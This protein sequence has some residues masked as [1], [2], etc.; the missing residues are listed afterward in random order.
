MPQRRKPGTVER[1]AAR[2][3]A[4]AAVRGRARDRTL[5]RSDPFHDG[6]LALWHQR[7]VVL[8][9]PRFSSATDPDVLFGFVY[10]GARTLSLAE[11]FH[12][13][14]RGGELRE[15]CPVCGGDLLV[16]NAGTGLTFTSASGVC[17][18]CGLWSRIVTGPQLRFAKVAFSQETDRVQRP[19]MRQRGRTLVFSDPARARSED[20]SISD[21]IGMLVPDGAGLCC[22]VPG[23]ARVDA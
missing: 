11:L 22:H 14:S 16:T 19:A 13:W 2:R 23:V 10:F 17:D 20:L 8:A 7:D 6:L 4:A 12:A 9:N 21:V 1:R 18:Q 15:T 5:T 3:Q